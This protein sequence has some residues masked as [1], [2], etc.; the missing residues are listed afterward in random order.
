[1]IAR[2][3]GDDAAMDSPASVPV[4]FDA[5]AADCR[6]RGLADLG[7]RRLTDVLNSNPELQ[8]SDARLE[9][10]DDGHV[11]EVPELEVGREELYAVV[12][13]GSRGDAARRV[14]THT[15][16]VAVELGVYHVEGHVHGTPASDPLFLALRRA[17]W[18]PLT[19]AT[20]SYRRGE[21]DVRDE[22]ETLLVNR[23]LAVSFKELEV[24]GAAVPWETARP[25]VPPSPRAVD[26]T[27]TLR[28]DAA[29]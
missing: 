16:R 18:V 15:T 23:T 12:A 9:A 27:G 29:I 26:L 17:A 24:D 28:D 25:A 10:L 20:I 21:E 1:M 4:Q 5:Y 7:D 2:S 3:T 19:D 8:L 22:F 14:R 6:L 11:V 13:N